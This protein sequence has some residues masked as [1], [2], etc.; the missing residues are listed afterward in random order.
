MDTKEIVIEQPELTEEE[1]R[2][3]EEAKKEFGKR[4]KKAFER[5][6]IADCGIFAAWEA[7]KNGTYVDEDEDDT[8]E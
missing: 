3:V 7:K 8:E 6:P 5:A 4:I 1:Q 2:K